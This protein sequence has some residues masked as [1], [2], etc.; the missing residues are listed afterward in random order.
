[1]KYL[2]ILSILTNCL[3]AKI[4]ISVSILPQQ[5]FVEKIGGDKVNVIAM[6]NPGDNPHSYE[7]KP[8]ELKEL[9]KAKIYFPMNIGFESAWLNRFQNQNKNMK[10]ISMTKGVKYIL[11][12][13]HKRNSKNEKVG[14]VKPDPHTWGSTLN[15]KIIAK[16]IYDALR[17]ID[18]KNKDYY[19]KNYLN[20]LNE[21]NTLDKEIRDILINVPTDTKF[22]VLHPSWGYF[23]RDYGLIQ[24]PIEIEGKTPKPKMLVELMKEAKKENIKAVFAQTE[25][26]NKNAQSVADYLKVKVLNKSALSKNWSDNLLKMANGIAYNQ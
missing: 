4:D 24:F 7:P 10:I 17:E 6:L 1:M 16:N 14:Y 3:F 13:K 18:V 8:S 9:S 23:A 20:F 11:M 25:F 22:M 5:T 19:K 26:S 2:L 12:K 21:I 15:V